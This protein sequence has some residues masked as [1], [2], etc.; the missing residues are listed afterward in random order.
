MIEPSLS[1]NSGGGF[2]MRNHFQK[3][4]GILNAARAAMVS[5]EYW[6]AYPESPA[7][8]LYARDAKAI[9]IFGTIMGRQS[10]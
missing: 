8:S 10:H 3:H 9:E 7:A 6:S 5:R 2:L 1:T 4:E